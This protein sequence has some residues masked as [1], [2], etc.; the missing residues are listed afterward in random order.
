LV[1]AKQAYLARTPQLGGVDDKAL[2]ITTL[3]GLPMLSIIMPGERIA[4]PTPDAPL[5]TQPVPEGPGAA[6]SLHIVDLPVATPLSA[7]QPVILK[8]ITANSWVTSTCLIGPD[9]VVVHP[10]QPVLPLVSQDVSATDLVLRGVGFLGGS[11][12]DEANATPLV[13]AATYDL[14]GV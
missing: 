1:R 8:N 12:S 13:S 9:G 11:Y 5:P 3:F 10:S 2:R 7:P 4:P 6:F 14:R